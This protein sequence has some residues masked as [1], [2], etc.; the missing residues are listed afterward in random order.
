MR[1]SRI[2]TF[3]A[4]ATATLAAESPQRPWT[5]T[6]LHDPNAWP[7]AESDVHIQVIPAGLRVEVAATRSF[8]IA[9]TSPLTLPRDFGRLRVVVRETGGGARWFV[10]L[11]GALREPDEHRTVGLAQDETATGERVFELDPRARTRTEAP[12]Q[13]QLGVEG[14]PGAHTVFEQLEFLPALRRTNCTPRTIFQ[15]HQKDIAAVE[16][17]PNLPEP[18]TLADWR[19]KAVAYDR[20]VFD[21]KAQGEFL[22]L[23]WLDD[24]RINVDRPTFGLPSYVGAPQQARSLTNSQEGITCIGAVLGATLVGIDKSRQEHD[25]PAMCEAWFNTA[26]GMNLVLNRQRDAAGASFWSEIF[27]HIAFYGLADLSLLQSLR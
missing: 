27:P 20:L 4:V 5:T 23:V 10:R 19:E 22:P 21:F 3:F 11:Y 2:L 7:H 17:M 9:A 15:P 1:T 6:V 24:S 25:Y 16:L 8:A 26:N 13:L 12:L 18:Y 14:E